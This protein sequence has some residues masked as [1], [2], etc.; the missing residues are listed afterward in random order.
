MIIH[1]RSP[2]SRT[3]GP[4][5]VS[6]LREEY[7]LMRTTSISDVEEGNDLDGARM[8]KPRLPGKYGGVIVIMVE[9]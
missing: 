1:V 9:L 8:Y 3:T 2:A 7:L 6:H 4:S 5:E